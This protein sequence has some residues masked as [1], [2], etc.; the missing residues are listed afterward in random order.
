MPDGDDKDDLFQE[1]FLKTYLNMHR[2]DP[3]KGCFHSWLLR[4][5]ANTSLDEL[6]RRRREDARNAETAR[7]LE[8]DPDESHD[9]VEKV[10]S[11]EG[12]RSALMSLPDPERQVILL[13]FY[14]DLKYREISGILDVPL[15]TVKSRMRSAMSRLRQ[16]I[17]MSEVGDLR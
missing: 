17:A 12:L 1:V 11:V 3:A 16:K 4:I 6:K 14:H 10:E 8:C 9:R 7:A 5:A 15:G 13:S 2:F